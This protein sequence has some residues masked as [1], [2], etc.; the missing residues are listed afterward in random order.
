MEQRFDRIDD[1]LD[2]IEEKL[3]NLA[4]EHQQRITKLETTQ[5]GVIALCMALLT[6]ALAALAKALHL[7]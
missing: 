7:T 5:K 1:K 6:T 3:S 4:M 2:S